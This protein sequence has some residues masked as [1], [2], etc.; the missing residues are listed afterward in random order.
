[1]LG[2]LTIIPWAR[3]GFEMVRALLAKTNLIS[4]KREWNNCFVKFRTIL[5]VKIIA[6][7]D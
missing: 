7:F 6:K 4:N 1:M 5:L 3:V 2:Y